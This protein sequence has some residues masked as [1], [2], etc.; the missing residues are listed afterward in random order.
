MTLRQYN[1]QKKY[2]RYNSYIKYRQF[3][4]K[5]LRR[6]IEAPIASPSLIKRNFDFYISVGNNCICAIT[7]KILNLRTYSFP[8]DWLCGVPLEKN[9]DWILKDFKDFL[10]YSDLSYPEEIL[11]D[12]LHLRVKNITTGTFFLHDFS[13]N[14]LQEFQSIK[15]KYHRRCERLL[16]SCE[17]KKLLFVYI[18]S[19]PDNIN[20]QTT[21]KEI[22]EKLNHVTEK[23]KAKE[24]KLVIL[25]SS[26]K[27][28]QELNVFRNHKSVLYFYGTPKA[29][30]FPFNG[31]EKLGLA[32]L[33]KEI[34]QTIE[35]DPEDHSA[36]H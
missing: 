28:T 36:P 1:L 35:E 16:Q 13:N 21:A 7:L 34:L 29:R 32:L 6:F 26:P 24:A 10:N 5:V 19:N 20:Y 17:N 25:H 23:L 4:P 18:E 9:L 15:Q 33:L 12:D 27:E 22:L 3:I 14:S 11:K 31:K 30:P 2:S 8:F